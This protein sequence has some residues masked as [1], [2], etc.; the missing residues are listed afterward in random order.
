MMKD[1]A[2]NI[3]M[4]MRLYIETDVISAT[5]NVMGVIPNTQK[6]TRAASLKQTIVGDISVLRADNL[7]CLEEM[8]PVTYINKNNIIIQTKRDGYS[9]VDCDKI[10]APVKYSVQLVLITAD[11]ESAY[12]EQKN[13]TAS[14][15]HAVR[16]Y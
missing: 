9:K 16:F 14:D 1:F 7:K 3:N 13:Y 8:N 4:N 5:R 12:L 15:F 11:G 10:G 2:G 6:G